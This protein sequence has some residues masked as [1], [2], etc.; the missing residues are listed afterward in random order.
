M[1]TELMITST[2]FRIYFSSDSV[3]IY[4]TLIHSYIQNILIL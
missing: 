1:K 2:E 4:I 3:V